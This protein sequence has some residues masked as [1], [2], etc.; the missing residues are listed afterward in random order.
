MKENIGAWLAL[1]RLPF[2]L[3]GVLPFILGSLLAWQNLGVLRWDIFLLGVAGV[4]LIMLATYWAGEY[5]DY[6]VDSLSAQKGSS[7]F[8]GGSQVLQR[9]LMQRRSALYA[10]LTAITLAATLGIVLQF[11]FLTGIWTI[12]LGIMGIIGGFFYSAK[13]IRWVSRGIGEI[14]IAFNYGWLPVATAFYLQ[15]GLFIP[16]IHFLAIPIGLTIFNVILLNEFP[17]YEA[18]T[19]T[20]KNNLVV[21]L[22]M[23]RAAILYALIGFASW[24]TM[25]FSLTLGFSILSCFL[26]FPVL[27]LSVSLVT[28]ILRG[29]W[30]NRDT[31]EKL[32]GLTII[33]N[34]GTTIVYILALLVL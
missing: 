4:V 2:H 10:S 9:G 31:L 29:S 22:G 34:L 13:P 3:V 30:Q 1:S 24:V 6:D 20:G 21:R 5:W 7:R 32:C 25:F 16:L 18:D 14:W 12:P 27:I 8:A 28:L 11:I 19:E 26:Y 33:V 15:V 17:D 23:R